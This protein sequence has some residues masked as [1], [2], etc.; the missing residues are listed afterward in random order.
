MGGSHPRPLRRRSSS[1][2]GVGRGVVPFC[3]GVFGLANCRV[4]CRSP[5]LGFEAAVGL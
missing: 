3:R 2:T 5:V 1:A 4:W